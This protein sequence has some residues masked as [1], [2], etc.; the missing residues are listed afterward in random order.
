MNIHKTFTRW[1]QA[2]MKTVSQSAS[3]RGA[4]CARYAH[5]CRIR[6][7]AVHCAC[8]RRE[9]IY[10]FIN[11]SRV[12]LSPEKPLANQNAETGEQ[13]RG[14]TRWNAS[15]K[16]L[17]LSG[18]MVYEYGIGTFCKLARTFVW[19]LTRIYIINLVGYFWLNEWNGSLIVLQS[20]A[21][22]QDLPRF[23]LR[24]FNVKM[25]VLPWR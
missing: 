9:L 6:T 1:A 24:H 23:A 3:K 20:R 15:K 22:W 12:D 14:R 25:C 4:S 13:A 19:T 2:Q 8:G 21:I 7:V 17:V 10:V 16:M 11:W 18:D 5:A